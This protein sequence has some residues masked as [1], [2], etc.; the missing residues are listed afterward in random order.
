MLN[1]Y[2]SYYAFS[3]TSIIWNGIRE[4]MPLISSHSRWLIGS[5]SKVNFWLDRWLE[6]PICSKDHASASSLSGLVSDIIKDSHWHIP[7]ILRQKMPTVIPQIENTSLPRSPTDDK[8]IWTCTADGS[9]TVSS[10]YNMLCTSR[11]WGPHIIPRNS[12]LGWRILRDRLPTNDNLRSRGVTVVSVC[13]LC[14]AWFS[15]P[16]DSYSFLISF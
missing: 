14:D 7:D 3:M 9:F 16:H 11:L 8:L 2:N 1:F 6:R 13:N 5:G 15:F 4:A 12:L 10:A